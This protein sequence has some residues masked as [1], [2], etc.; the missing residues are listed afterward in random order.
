MRLGTV[1]KIGVLCVALSAGAGLAAIAYLFSQEDYTPQPG[2]L[3]YYLGI[4]S[5][6]RNAPIA[7][8]LQ[9]AEY[10]G[11]VGD[12]NKLPQ[13]QVSFYVSQ[14]DAA[15]AWRTLQR[16]LDEQGF[17]HAPPDSGSQ[18][19]T[20]STTAKEAQYTSPTDGSVL[21]TLEEVPA[22]A[23]LRVSLTHFD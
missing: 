8:A 14:A 6:V 9:P 12:G 20:A 15:Q 1:L 11:S 18:A 3:T 21:M 22:A 10:F 23:G 2:S 13:S 4:S 17:S 16:Y 7:A 19:Q 5:L